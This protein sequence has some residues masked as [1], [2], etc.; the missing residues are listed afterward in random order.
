[1]FFN[2]F[3]ALGFV[4]T[5]IVASLRALG[6]TFS[7][8]KSAT[9]TPDDG[10]RGVLIEWCVSAGKTVAQIWGIREGVTRQMRL[11]GLTLTTLSCLSFHS[12]TRVKQFLLA[13]NDQKPLR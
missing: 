1:M 13:L 2:V 3:D 5:A 8:P 9:E 7:G 6:D 12:D 4:P 11:R 10:N